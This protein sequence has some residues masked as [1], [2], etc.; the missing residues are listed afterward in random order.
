MAA[1]GT[2]LTATQA[3]RR[4]SYGIDAP[5]LL[6]ILAA[7]FIANLADG[8]IS[9]KLWPFLGAAV[10][11][12]CA[13]LGMYASRRGKFA[14]WAELLDRLGLRGDELVLDIGCG[15]GAVLMMAAERLTT[16]RAIGIDLW[17][18]GDQ[19]GNDLEAT[20]RN[21][22]AEGVVDRVELR[23]GDM[24]ALPFENGSFDVVLSSIAIHNVNRLGRDKVMQEAVR[25]L[26]P[27]GK[28]MIADLLATRQYLSR[29]QALGMTSVRRAGLGWRMWW[30]GPWLSTFLVAAIKP[31]LPKGPLKVG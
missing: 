15:R 19:S 2:T 22:V 23:T 18:K 17:K 20:Q 12:C 5:K 30:T 26:R 21:A 16:G 14:V 1:A 29:L 9:G 13:G 27:G 3:P 8:V 6:P 25:V 10:I 31:T 7:L 28:L 24:T 11:L 4:G